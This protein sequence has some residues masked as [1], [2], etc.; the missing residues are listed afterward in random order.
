MNKVGLKIRASLVT[1]IF[2]KT[3]SVSS[4]SMS[5]FSTGEVQHSIHVPLLYV[6]VVYTYTV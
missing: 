6:Q 4:V 5:K 3:L 1:E 2:R